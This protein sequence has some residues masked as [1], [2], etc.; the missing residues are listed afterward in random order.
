MHCWI[1]EKPIEGK[2]YKVLDHYAPY[3]RYHYVHKKCKRAYET[4][5]P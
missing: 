5:L 4:K 3:E 2:K 1:C